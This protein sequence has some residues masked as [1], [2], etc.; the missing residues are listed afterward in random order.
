MDGGGWG[1]ELGVTEQPLAVHNHCLWLH[2]QHC[3]VQVA[4]AVFRAACCCGRY[5]HRAC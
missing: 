1:G 4:T 2:I 3:T 5:T